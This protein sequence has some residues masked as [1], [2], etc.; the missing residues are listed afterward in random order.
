MTGWA[1]KT[2][3]SGG[4]ASADETDAVSRLSDHP[5]ND[6]Q[7]VTWVAAGPNL[8]QSFAPAN[9]NSPRLA[10]VDPGRN[11]DLGRST[12][13]QSLVVEN[14]HDAAVQD[15]TKGREGRS[16]HSDWNNRRRIHASQGSAVVLGFQVPGE[17][18]EEGATLDS[19]FALPRMQLQ[20][21]PRRTYCRFATAEDVAYWNQHLD[22][23]GA[24]IVAVDE[25]PLAAEEE[26]GEEGEENCSWRGEADHVLHTKLAGRLSRGHHGH[27]C[28]DAA[29]CADMPH[30]QEQTLGP[31]KKQE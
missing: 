15:G 31:A 10:A 22:W 7:Q 21:A 26:E 23:V 24:G 28:L 6:I 4:T 20:L 1:L 13:V 30:G 25:S 11:L 5:R 19:Y 2:W 17:A 3:V 8:G 29:S 27:P 16:A 9:S 12:A 14:T 18:R